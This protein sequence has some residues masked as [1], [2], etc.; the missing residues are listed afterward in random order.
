MALMGAVTVATSQPGTCAACHRQQS[1]E[2]TRSAHG[3]VTCY[4]CH[5]N[6]GAWGFAEAKATEFGRMYPQALLGDG[7]LKGPA[8]RMARRSCTQCHTSVLSESTAI[9]GLKIE[10]SQCAPGKCDTCHST[11]AHVS[12]RWP[13]TPIMGDCVSCHK[14]SKASERCDACHEGRIETARLESGPWQ[15]THGPNWRSTHGM[16]DLHTCSSCHE[17]QDCVKCHGVPMPHDNGFLNSHGK[18]ALTKEAKCLGCHRSKDW[19]N[20]CHG[21]PMPHPAKFLSTHPKTARSYQ[22]KRCLACHAKNDCSDCHTRHIHPGLS[23]SNLKALND[24]VGDR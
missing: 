1:E 2:W 8:P 18:V 3:S 21:V 15:V 10:H 7:S 9:R 17:A 5:L 22:D 13:R 23:G 12:V 19:C 14:E 20:S 6:N 24:A 4:D 16:G 11:V